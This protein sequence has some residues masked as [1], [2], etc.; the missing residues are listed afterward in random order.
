MKETQAIAQTTDTQTT[1]IRRGH[2]RSRYHGR[3]A[4]KGTGSEKRY[5]GDKEWDLVQRVD[6]GSGWGFAPCLPLG[7]R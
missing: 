1:T 5:A 6:Q 3:I 4:C 2:G 7:I